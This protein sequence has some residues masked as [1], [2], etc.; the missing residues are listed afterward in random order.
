MHKGN[1]IYH[2]DDDDDDDLCHST[3]MLFSWITYCEDPCVTAVSPLTHIV[4][5]SI[6]IG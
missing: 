4:F 1:N 2:D 3:G 5:H 6:S